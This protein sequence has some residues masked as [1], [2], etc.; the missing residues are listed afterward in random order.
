MSRQ[1]LD[2]IARDD[3]YPRGEADDAGVTFATPYLS[4]K[5]IVQIPQITS[6]MFRVNL[7]NCS[8]KGIL[9]DET[10]KIFLGPLRLLDGAHAG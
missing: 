10:K 1:S 4:T 7:Y 3:V 5:V 8:L 2:N 9:L 6:S